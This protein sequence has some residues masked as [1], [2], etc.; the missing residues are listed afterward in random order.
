MSISEGVD[1]WQSGIREL[2][3]RRKEE[4]SS[5]NNSRTRFNPGI[6]HQDT[7]GNQAITSVVATLFSKKQQ[8][9]CFWEA[10][11]LKC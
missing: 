5:S 2:Q 11:K 1:Q 9:N 10:N 8:K 7:A 4:L 6:R 3:N